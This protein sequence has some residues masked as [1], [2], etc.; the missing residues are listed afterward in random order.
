MINA[1]EKAII[2]RAEVIADFNRLC[3]E[4]RIS[5]VPMKAFVDNR[6]TYNEVNEEIYTALFMS[7]ADTGVQ[8]LRTP[9]EIRDVDTKPVSKKS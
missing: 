5:P 3:E 7:I 2:R 4:G 9:G 8:I 1:L 6:I